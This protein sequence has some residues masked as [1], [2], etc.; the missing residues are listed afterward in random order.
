MKD[1]QF[2]AAPGTFKLLLVF[3]LGIQEHDIHIKDENVKYLL[4][5]LLTWSMMKSLVL[6]LLLVIM[7]FIDMIT[8][9]ETEGSGVDSCNNSIDIIV[10]NSRTTLENNIT[11]VWVLSGAQGHK[12]TSKIK[13]E[14]DNNSEIMQP[15]N[16]IKDS[17]MFI[18]MFQ[19]L[20]TPLAPKL[21]ATCKLSRYQRLSFSAQRWW[22]SWNTFS[23][24]TTTLDGLKSACVGKDWIYTADDDWLS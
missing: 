18:C 5:C 14:E 4:D 17:W 10:P 9:T 2:L 6:L 11:K 8:N 22:R 12:H 20:I 3:V 24:P 19:L 23:A 21:S 13:G 1:F 16:T 7:T 15:W